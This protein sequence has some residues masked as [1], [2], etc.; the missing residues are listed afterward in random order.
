MPVVTF[1]TINGG[2][3]SKEFCLQKK[4]RFHVVFHCFNCSESTRPSPRQDKCSNRQPS[5]NHRRIGC[6]C[7]RLYDNCLHHGHHLCPK[8][9]IQHHPICILNLRDNG[10]S[11]F[12]ILCSTISIKYRK[13][14]KNIAYSANISPWYLELFFRFVCGIFMSYWLVSFSYFMQLL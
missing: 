7:C 11:Y 12:Q 9:G 14:T 3:C 4:S 8:V 6:R 2:L 10:L 1:P 13:K 5:W